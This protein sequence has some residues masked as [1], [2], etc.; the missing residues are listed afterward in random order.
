MGMGAVTRVDDR[1]AG[2]AGDV[3]GQSRAAVAHDDEIGAHRLQ[4][5]DGF[6]NRLTL[7]DGRVGDVEVG[8]IGGQAFGGDL[9]GRMGAGARLIEEHQHG[10]SLECGD[11]LHRAGEDLLEGCGLIEEM[12]DFPAFKGDNI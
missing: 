4:G 6:S 11:F 8:D 7:G 3:A 2:Q 9:E 10:F 5:L 12:L 1:G